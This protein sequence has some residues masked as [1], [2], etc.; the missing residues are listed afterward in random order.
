MVQVRVEIHLRKGVTDPEGENVQKALKLLGFLEVRRV[1]SSKLFLIELAG[2][3][4]KAARKQVE[5]MC[6]RL[7]AN[8]VIHEYAISIEK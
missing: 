8:P 1:R 2:T 3:D 7:L 6:R 4:A 5:E